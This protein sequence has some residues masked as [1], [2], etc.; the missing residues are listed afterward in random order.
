MLKWVHAYRIIHFLCKHVRALTLFNWIE[1]YFFL[2]I[3]DAIPSQGSVRFVNLP[4]KS[5]FVLGPI[6]IN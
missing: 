5:E 6:T 3:R 4:K 1:V 2:D